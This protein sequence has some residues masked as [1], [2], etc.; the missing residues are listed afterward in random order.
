MVSSV[1]FRVHVFA[2]KRPDRRYPITTA[3]R[4]DGGNAGNGSQ[5]MS[6]DR[7]DLKTSW[8]GRWGS[9]PHGQASSENGQTSRAEVGAELG[10]EDFAGGVAGQS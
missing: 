5:P 3:R 7:T 6:S 4:A 2:A 10:L 9:T 1:V 8:S